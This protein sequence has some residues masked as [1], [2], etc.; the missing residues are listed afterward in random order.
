MY[1]SLF[2]SFYEQFNSS[3]ILIKGCVQ[4]GFLWI[5][6]DFDT[7]LSSGYHKSTVFFLGEL[8]CLS[9]KNPIFSSECPG[10]YYFL[11]FLRGTCFYQNNLVGVMEWL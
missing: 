9:Q 8:V 3:K 11:V 6:S 4:L 2:L 10:E 1:L 5:V 7:N